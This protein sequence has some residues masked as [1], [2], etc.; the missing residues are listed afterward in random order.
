MNAPMSPLQLA[1][2]QMEIDPQACALLQPQMP[3]ALAVQT[4]LDAG[5][6]QPALQLAARLLPKRYVVAWLCQCARGQALA[7]ESRAGA[8][9]AERWLREPSEGN[10]RAAYEFANA[11]GYRDLGAWL[12]ASAGWADGS[13]APPRQQT[14]VVPPDHLTARAAVAAL[15]LLA[16]LDLEHFQARRRGYAQQV[17]GLLA[18]AA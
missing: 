17:L 7:P 11:G 12:A 10:R 9:L 1:C 14:A 3:A 13:L 18:G 4:L 5:Q 16:A 2:A 6:V 8:M 15:N